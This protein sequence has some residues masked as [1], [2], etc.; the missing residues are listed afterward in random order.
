[1]KRERDVIMK[2]ID[3]AE[4]R[5]ARGKNYDHELAVRDRLMTRLLQIDIPT[6][7]SFEAFAARYTKVS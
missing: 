6:F 3:K 1:M 4:R 7:P 2:R 5:I